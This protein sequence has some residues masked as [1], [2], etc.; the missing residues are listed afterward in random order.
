[1]SFQSAQFTPRDILDLAA[2]E[3]RKPG[4]ALVLAEE[5]SDVLPQIAAIIVPRLAST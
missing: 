1:L 4:I 2:V 5:C 3:R